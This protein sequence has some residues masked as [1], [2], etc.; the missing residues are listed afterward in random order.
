MDVLRYIERN[1]VRAGLVKRAQDWRFSSAALAGSGSF[2][3]AVGE[4]VP[5]PLLSAP[6]HS[7][8]GSGTASRSQTPFREPDPFSGP[9]SDE[10]AKPL[11]HWLVRG[12]GERP[13]PWLRF[14]NREE[15]AEE[16]ARLRECVNRGSP[17]GDQ[18][19]RE[20]AAMK[21]G[22]ESTIRP[23]GRPRNEIK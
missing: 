23:R 3:P 6:A 2:S 5:D 20:N 4:K 7:E 10:P 19:W 9:D 18:T 16:L 15:Q 22:L 17:Y 13:D 14:V 11:A 12:P 1:P 21:L 8:K